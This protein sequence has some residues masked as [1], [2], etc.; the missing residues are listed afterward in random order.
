MTRLVSRDEREVGIDLAADR[1]VFLV[2]AYG[3]LGLVAYRAFALGESSWDLLGLV[4]VGG[5]VGLAYRLQKGVV[6]SRWAL[7]LVATV[8]VAAILA[9][10]L[11]LQLPR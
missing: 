8:I 2:L 10:G 6:S 3:L 9:A 4:I 7:V 5:L 1:L 11:A